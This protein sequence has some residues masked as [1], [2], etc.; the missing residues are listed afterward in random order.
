MELNK[1]N[2]PQGDQRTLEEMGFDSVEKIALSSEDKLGLGKKGGRIVQRARNTLAYEH[3]RAISVSEGLITIT[4]GDSSKATIT[5][6]EDVLGILYTWAKRS[7]DN[8][9]SIART[10]DLGKNSKL[11]VYGLR[12]VKPKGIRM[13]LPRLK[14]EGLCKALPFCLLFIIRCCF[15]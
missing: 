6:V 13:S 12:L 1:L 7:H 15:S 4:L 2:L 5:S 9:K 11:K 3:I 10:N 14:R 8:D